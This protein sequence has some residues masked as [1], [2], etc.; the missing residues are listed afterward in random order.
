MTVLF[1]V[2]SRDIV[3]QRLV[4]R[5]DGLGEINR[6]RGI[7][8]LVWVILE[9]QLSV[10]ALNFLRARPHA[11]VQDIVRI[12][13]FLLQRRFRDVHGQRDHHD[14]PNRVPQIRPSK[15]SAHAPPRRH[16]TPFHRRHRRLS[17]FALYITNLRRQRLRVLLRARRIALPLSAHAFLRRRRA[18]QSRDRRRD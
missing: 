9:R 7:R 17:P 3:R 15:Q 18:R 5:R 4:R 11:Q 10:R 12:E 14:P 16:L 6:R 13:P 2:L 8:V 1:V